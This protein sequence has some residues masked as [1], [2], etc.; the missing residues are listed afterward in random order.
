MVEAEKQIKRCSYIVKRVVKIS[1]E[2]TTYFR[3]VQMAGILA[4]NSSE[5]LGG[6]L[7]Q[8]DDC[9]LDFVTNGYAFV[10]YFSV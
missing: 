8:I 9:Y 1:T 3:S 10:G 2:D 7:Y 4:L 5:K 6:P